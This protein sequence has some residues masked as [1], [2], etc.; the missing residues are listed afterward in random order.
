MKRIV[1]ILTLT[2][3]TM[4]AIPVLADEI[5]PPDPNMTG[6]ITAEPQ[7]EFIFFDIFVLR[8]LGVVSMALGA[9]SA[10]VAN[11]VASMSHSEDRVER[12]FIQKP[13]WYTFC[14]PVGDIDF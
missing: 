8:P 9:A 11:P 4:T 3:L 7:G 5:L 2:L 13:Y 6:R 14:R 12:E 1:L 10:L